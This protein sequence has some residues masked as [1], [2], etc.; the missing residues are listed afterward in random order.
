MVGRAFGFGGDVGGERGVEWMV[1]AMV[2]GWSGHA[3]FAYIT[4][5]CYVRYEV[6]CECSV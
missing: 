2:V 5:G 1:V 6:W 4:I 3:T